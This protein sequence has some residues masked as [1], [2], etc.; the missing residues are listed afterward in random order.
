MKK[1]KSLM[2]LTATMLL[3]AVMFCVNVSAAEWVNLKDSIYYSF[4][5]ETGVMVL[6]GEGDIKTDYFYTDCSDHFDETDEELGCYCSRLDL[7]DWFDIEGTAEYR[8]A[9]KTK[10]VVVQEGITSL[11]VGVFRA[12]KNLEV[13]IL[14]KSVTKIPT[15]AFCNLKKLHT[16]AF[17]SSATSIGEY[18]FFGCSNLRSIYIPDTVKTIG[19]SAFVGCNKKIISIP[20]SV[21][22]A[23]K[24][25]FD[26]GA[27]I[28]FKREGYKVYL[29]AYTKSLLPDDYRYT[30]PQHDGSEF[31]S[32]DKTTKKY[33]KL[34]EGSTS[35]TLENL[36]PGKTYY[37][38]ARRYSETDTKRVYSLKS[39]MITVTMPPEKVSGITTTQTDSTITINWKASEN[40]DGYRVF[41]ANRYGL[42]EK[43]AT[44]TKLTYTVKDLEAAKIKWFAV[45][46]YT[47]TED[48]ILWGGYDKFRSTTAPVNPTIKVAAPSKGKV[49]V[50][51][52]AVDGADAYQLWYK[53]GNGS[54]KLYKTYDEVQNLTFNNLKSGT[55]YTFAVRAVIRIDGVNVRSGYKAVAVTVK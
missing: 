5:E 38:V 13:A 1:M 43:V 34:G 51:W 18:A 24:L 30:G 45:R 14:P 55:K 3:L 6:K 44:T 21:E 53:I 41:M 54:Y 19:I 8:A 7:E 17:S 16:V 48:E 36:K 2:L 39:D 29:N 37:I 32:Y 47:K 42:Y 10:T 52:N 25:V 4:D 22:N 9:Q 28:T 26:S 27:T 31:Y 11:P 35:I 20:A 46:P 12:F 40:A 15:G 50:N 49:T 33:T 23:D